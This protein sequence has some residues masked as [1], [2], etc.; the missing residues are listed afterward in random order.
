MTKPTLLVI[1]DP[2]DDVKRENFVETFRK[3]ISDVV[4]QDVQLTE[5]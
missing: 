3:N 2:V 5:T 4:V 1:F